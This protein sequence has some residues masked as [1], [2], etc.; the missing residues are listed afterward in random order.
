MQVVST[1]LNYAHTPGA[2]ER[3]EAFIGQVPEGKSAMNLKTNARTIT[4]S[5]FRG[6]D[7]QL[8]FRSAGFKLVQLPVSKDLDW[9]AH[10]QVQ[11]AYYAALENTVKQETGATRVH[12]FDHTIREGSIRN[13][14]SSMAPG[15]M[16]GF[17]AQPA[18]HAHV[19]YT[20]KS[21]IER[22]K[23]VLPEEAEKLSQTPFAVIQ[24]WQ[25]IKGP[26]KDSPLA[27]ADASTVAMQDLLPVDL[28]FP[29]RKGQTYALA[30]NPAHR[31][32]YA[33]DM[34]ADEALLFVG[35]DSR[36]D[37]RARFTP[38]TSFVDPNAPADAPVRQ[39]IEFRTYAFWED[40]A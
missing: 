17:K 30:Y 39:S 23:A 3:L 35:Y 28:H 10:D 9:A 4:V 8:D 33:A 24:A 32:Y 26:V 19:D 31:W 37:G 27:L 12:V 2:G 21:G 34:T 38:H 13:S 16:S 1:T 20:I 6:A 7:C 40:E 29:T 15:R 5:S 14:S 22:L 11:A 18:S 25:P 36:L